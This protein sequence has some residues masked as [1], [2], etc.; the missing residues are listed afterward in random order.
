[1][2]VHHDASAVRLGEA[3]EAA[4]ERRLPRAALTDQREALAAAH[5]ERDL[6]ERDQPAVSLG[7]S[8]RE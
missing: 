8:L 2:P 6:I 5:L 3:I 4:K 1:M 7:D